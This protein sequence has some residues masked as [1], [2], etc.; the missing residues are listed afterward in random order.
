MGL[1]G[2]AKKAVKSSAALPFSAFGNGTNV[3][4]YT[5]SV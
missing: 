3:P 2:K 1:C 4:V 5:P